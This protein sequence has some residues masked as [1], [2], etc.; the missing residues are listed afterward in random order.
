[1]RQCS[2]MSP[3]GE[4]A[5]H[6]GVRDDAGRAARKKVAHYGLNHAFKATG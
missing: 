3:G 5:A 1:M 2:G 6:A 4:P